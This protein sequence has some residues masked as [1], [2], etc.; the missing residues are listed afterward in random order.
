TRRRP[1][2]SL[3]RGRFTRRAACVDA[4]QRRSDRK[5]AGAGRCVRRPADRLGLHE[6]ANAAGVSRRSETGACGLKILWVNSNFMHPT[7]KGGSIRTLEMLGRLSRRHE[8]HFAAIEDP[9]HPEGPGRAHEYSA[10]HYSSRHAIP[11][12]GTA[13]FALQMA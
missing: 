2:P 13:A 1:A 9:A 10:R 11:E 6:N 12:R 4:A 8:I 7:N 5:S 3:L